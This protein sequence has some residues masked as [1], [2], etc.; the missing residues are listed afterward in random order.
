MS[1]AQAQN[2]DFDVSSLFA[3]LLNAQLLKLH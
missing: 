2:E 3:D 1:Q